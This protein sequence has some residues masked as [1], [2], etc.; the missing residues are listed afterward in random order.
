MKLDIYELI[1]QTQRLEYN[2][3]N[4]KVTLIKEEY[5]SEETFIK[6]IKTLID[7]IGSIPDK[8]H[9]NEDEIN[10]YYNEYSNVGFD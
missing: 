6:N 1:K 10:I 7:N 2:N 9:Y 8:I 3:N 5:I 4:L